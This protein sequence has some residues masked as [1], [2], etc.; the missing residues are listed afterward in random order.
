MPDAEPAA[1]RPEGG[2]P[3][4]THRA[5]GSPAAPDAAD[6]SVTRA[7][8]AAAHV[9]RLRFAAL[10]ESEG[11]SLTAYLVGCAVMEAGPQTQRALALRADVSE[12]TLGRQVDLMEREGLVTRRRPP[13]D[14]RRVL[15]DL[16]PQGAQRHAELSRLAADFDARLVQDLGLRSARSVSAALRRLATDPARP[17][18]A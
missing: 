2:D 3:A 9:V 6:R 13:D 8:L 15:V 11:G 7:L 14:R 5:A 16:T 17:D 12:A 10:L 4:R 18:P 1:A